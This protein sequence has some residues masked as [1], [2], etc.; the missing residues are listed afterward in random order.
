MFVST[1]EHANGTYPIVKSALLPSF[2]CTFGFQRVTAKNYAD[3]I[4]QA[5]SKSKSLFSK[6]CAV[7]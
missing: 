3:R 4:I 1:D 5:L 2:S 6:M 7:F